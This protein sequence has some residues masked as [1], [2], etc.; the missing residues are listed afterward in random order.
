MLSEEDKTLSL[1]G[2]IVNKYAVKP[3]IGNTKVKQKQMRIEQDKEKQ[4]KRYFALT[5]RVVLLD[6]VP[7]TKKGVAKP[8]PKKNTVRINRSNPLPKLTPEVERS[9]IKKIVPKDNIPKPIEKKST[10]NVKSPAITSTTNSPAIS[11]PK[12]SP[13]AKISPAKQLTPDPELRWE[14]IHYLAAKPR[15]I[16]DCMEKTDRS[17]EVILNALNE[18]LFCVIVGWKAASF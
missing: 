15:L 16:S 18:V 4:E 12:P 6:D 13:T 7:V 1:V 17:E 10:P 8:A 3:S 11:T 14:L 9:E 5:L 2:T